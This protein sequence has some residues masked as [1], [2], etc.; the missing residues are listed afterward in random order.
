MNGAKLA[1][2]G[3]TRKSGSDRRGTHREEQVPYGKLCQGE[4]TPGKVEKEAREG[5]AWNKEKD[6]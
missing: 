4:K 2:Q 1:A 3:K 6:P 5:G